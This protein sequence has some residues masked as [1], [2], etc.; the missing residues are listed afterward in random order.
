MR[1]DTRLFC[2]TSNR[3][4]NR[5]PGNKSVGYTAVRVDLEKKDVNQKAMHM[6]KVLWLGFSIHP[7][8]MLPHNYISVLVAMQNN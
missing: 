6:N 4:L 8:K 2:T 1:L 5:G 7:E 3:K